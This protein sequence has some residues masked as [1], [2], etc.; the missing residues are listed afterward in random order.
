MR[1]AVLLIALAT[2]AVPLTAIADETGFAS[3]HNWRKEGDRI[4]LS[5]HFHDG[6]GKGQHRKAAEVNAVASWASFTILEYGTTWGLYALA[7]NKKITC[8]PNGG[9]SWFCDVTA[10]PCKRR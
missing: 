9:T 8:A 5:N 6:T 2:G 7:A 10:R 3:I 1:K 4:C